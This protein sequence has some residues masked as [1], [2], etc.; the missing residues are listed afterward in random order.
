MFVFVG[1]VICI[2]YPGLYFQPEE[3]CIRFFG[4]LEP[5]NETAYRRSDVKRAVLIK[6]QAF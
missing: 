6:I 5:I 4:K 1:L 2:S 3:E